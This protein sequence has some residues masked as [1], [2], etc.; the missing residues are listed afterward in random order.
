MQKW[1]SV[2][3]VFSG[4]YLA[5]QGS[6]HAQGTS[7]HL[8]AGYGTEDATTYDLSLQ[9]HFAPWIS[10][11]N[12]A[13]TPFIL[14]GIST[15]RNGSHASSM[16]VGYLSAG[17]TLELVEFNE[18]RP[19]TSVSFGGALLSDESYGKRKLG[20]HGQFRSQGSIGLKFG[21]SLRHYVRIDATHYSNAHLASDN[22]GYNIIGLSYGFTF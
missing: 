20:S 17:V 1:I 19:F 16:W 3:A 2:I 7:L 5:G 10:G 22:D 4:L 18:W 13:L 11:E 15:W 6:V 9:H 21:T 14:G 12:A 8:G